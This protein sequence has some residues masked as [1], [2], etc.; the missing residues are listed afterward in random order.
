M[1]DFVSQLKTKQSR[2]A[3][4]EWLP[5][6]AVV[7]AYARQTFLTLFSTPKDEHPLAF[8]LNNDYVYERF[9]NII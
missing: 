6:P 7:Y 1:N 3:A 8:S 2:V 9:R 4:S 5:P